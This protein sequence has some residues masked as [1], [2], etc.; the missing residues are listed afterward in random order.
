VIVSIGIRSPPAG[1]RRAVSRWLALGWVSYGTLLGL[2]ALHPQLEQRHPVRPGTV[3]LP[4]WRVLVFAVLAFG[5][6]ISLAA[7]FVRTGATGGYDVAGVSAALVAAALLLL[8]MVIRLAMMA[9]VAQRRADELAN[10]SA[11]LATAVS[12]QARLQQQL[13]YRAVHDPLT[14]LANRVLLIERMDAVLGRR[15]GTSVHALLMVDLD[16]FK[17]I[18]DTLGHPVG[19]ESSSRSPRG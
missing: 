11:A 1:P 8:L 19:D 10:R 16:G 13:A 6:P 5:V 17:D 15:G 4:G 14:G 9:R 12:Q 3:G 18:N 2:I 7:E